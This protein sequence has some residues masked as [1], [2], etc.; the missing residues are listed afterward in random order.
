ML[1]SEGL[2]DSKTLCHKSA[3]VVDPDGELGANSVGSGCLYG[4]PGGMIDSCIFKL[5]VLSR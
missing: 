3:I 4:S 5:D 1:K 2:K